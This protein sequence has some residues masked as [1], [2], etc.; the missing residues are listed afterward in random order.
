MGWGRDGDGMG[1]GWSHPS[2]GMW[3]PRAPALTP[4]CPCPPRAAA[5]PRGPGDPRRGPGPCSTP[6]GVSAEPG[7]GPGAAP[8]SVIDPDMEALFDEFL[9]KELSPELTGPSAAPPLP[10]GRP[11]H[12]VLRDTEQ[13]GLCL[14]GGRLVPTPL[15]GASADQEEIFSAVPNP[16]LER[17]RC[18]LIVGIRGGSQALSCT[19][20][21]EPRLQLVAQPKAAAPLTPPPPRTVPPEERSRGVPAAVPQRCPPAGRGAAGAVLAPAPS[22]RA[23]G[24]STHSFEAA[25]CPGAFL[26]TAGGQELGLA[27]PHGATGFY[28]HRR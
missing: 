9:G 5:G 20:G 19:P 16:H 1:T 13:R 6:M 3:H 8:E 28:L 25:A 12:F 23:S 11:H 15:Q 4:T 2:P 21:P 10:R 14:R 27:P 24:G 7:A 17:R 18:P 26:S 22:T